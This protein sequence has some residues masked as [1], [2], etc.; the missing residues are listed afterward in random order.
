MKEPTYCTV[1]VKFVVLAEDAGSV[2]PE[3]YQSESFLSSCVLSGDIAEST[4][5]E[6]E[7]IK[8]I[9]AEGACE[10]E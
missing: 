2:M 1:T 10:E 3:L 4:P 5:Q 9:A 7:L 8:I 6:I